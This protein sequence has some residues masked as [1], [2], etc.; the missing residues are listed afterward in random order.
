M[1]RINLL[2]Q[3]KKGAAR[4]APVDANVPRMMG[5]GLGTL[6]LAA[7]GVF[8]FVHSPLLDEIRENE[9][10]N[11]RLKK[12]IAKLKEDTKDFDTISKQFQA[13]KEQAEAIARLNSA[14]SVPAWLLNELSRILTKGGSPTMTPEMAER[15]K[16]D[17]NRQWAVG[18][19]PKRVWI[20]SFVEK[21]GKFT[22]KG[23]AQADA[24]ITQLALRL[25]AS[26]YFTSVVLEMGDRATDKDKVSYYRFTI[27]GKVAY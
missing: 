11:A 1:I 27:S 15:V 7:I 17:H 3:K 14:R 25:Q 21:D 6:A 22:L 26:A 5:I 20:T 12:S 13:A 4:G 2:P 18:W 23:G 8:F 16:T 10:A 24:D 9:E 19:D